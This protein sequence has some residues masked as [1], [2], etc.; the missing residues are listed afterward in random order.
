[1]CQ[2]ARVDGELPEGL[3]VEIMAVTRPARRRDNL[4][5]RQRSSTALPDAGVPDSSAIFQ[6]V[7]GLRDARA[8]TAPPSSLR[9]AGAGGERRRSCASL[10]LL[11]RDVPAF[12][13]GH[14]CAADWDADGGVRGRAHASRP[15]RCPSVEVP[16]TTPDIIDA[17]RQAD[18][19]ADGAARRPRRGGRRFGVAAVDRRRLQ[20]VDRRAEEAHP[21]LDGPEH[22]Q[23]A[24]RTPAALRDRARPDAGR[25]SRS[26]LRTRRLQRPSS[27]PTTRCCSSSSGAVIRRARRHS[28]RSTLRI[29]VEGE[30]HAADERGARGGRSRSPSCSP[31]SGRQREKRRRRS[32]HRRAHLLP[33]GRRQDRGVPRPDRVLD[34]LP[35]A[36]R[37][38]DAGVDVLM[39]YTLRL[40][41]AQQFQRASALICAMEHLAQDEES[42]SSA[43][44]EFSIGVWLGGRVTPNTATTRLPRSGSCKREGRRAENTFVLL[45]C[46]WCAAQMGPIRQTGKAAGRRRGPEPKVAGY[47]R[48]RRTPSVLRCPDSTLRVPPGLPVYVVDEDIYDDA[49]VAGHRHGRQ[50]R[51]ARVPARGARALR[52]RPR[53]HRGARARRT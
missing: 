9:R 2:A 20:R 42:P 47:D 1:M 18:R 12:A 24:A 44:A 29:E 31:R 22:Q 19:S 14:G 25:A 50:V 46:P 6:A 30:L 51:D 48:A 40:L 43:T 17:D 39:R 11:Y 41:T 7:H 10:A 23:T 36:G 28:T 26:S 32:R 35:P 52:H 21:G 33:D 3:R 53:R 4:V 38:G 34:L 8:A 37:P 5:D 15:R 13:V 27:S 45:R 49:A 16:S